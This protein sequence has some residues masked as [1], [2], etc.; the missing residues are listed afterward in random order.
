LASSLASFLWNSS[1]L[2]TFIQSEII[3]FQVDS[4]K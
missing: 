2:F 4:K 1:F 3:C